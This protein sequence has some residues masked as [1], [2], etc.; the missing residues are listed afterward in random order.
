MCTNSDSNCVAFCMCICRA[1]LVLSLGLSHKNKGP[2]LHLLGGLIRRFYLHV[3]FSSLVVKPLKW[4]VE[5]ALVKPNYS[6][7][8]WCCKGK[9]SELLSVGEP[10]GFH[11]IHSSL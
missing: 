6:R 4:L 1:L 9:S 10:L 7:V 2:F 11:P 3:N 8:L 5:K